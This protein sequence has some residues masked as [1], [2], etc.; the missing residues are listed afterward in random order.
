MCWPA[1]S[2]LCMK[3]VSGCVVGNEC[4]DIRFVNVASVSPASSRTTTLNESGANRNSDR[5]AES[6]HREC[7][8]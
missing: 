2:G 4:E 7:R 3:K 8:L 5:R 6:G 1:L